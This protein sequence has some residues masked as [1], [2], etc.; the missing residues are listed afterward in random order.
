MFV[1][2]GQSGSAFSS[3]NTVFC[4]CSILTIFS[5]GNP[6]MVITGTIPSPGW[7]VKLENLFLRRALWA[8]PAEEEG[9]LGGTVAVPFTWN[10]TLCSRVLLGGWKRVR[11]VIK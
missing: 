4:S 8:V 2:K 7:M 6:E 3:E 10:V 11:F 5:F 9:V 1:W